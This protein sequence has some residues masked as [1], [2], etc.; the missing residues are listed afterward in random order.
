[1]AAPGRLDDLDRLL[2]LDPGGRGV[3]R[4]ATPG[5]ALA[6]A[7][8]LRRAR[9]VVIVTGFCVPPGIPE[10]DGPPGTAVLGRALRRLGARVRYVTDAAVRGSLAASL[11][12]LGEPPD[13]DVYHPGAEA[14]RALLGRETPSHLIAIE[15]PGRTT[16]G[17][18]LSARGESV[19]PWNSPLD[20][21]FVLAGK[22]VRPQ[23][24]RSSNRP[25]TA[26][27][28][29]A[30]PATFAV[31]DGGNEIGMG[32]VRPRLAREGT[33]MARIASAVRVDYLVVAGVSNWGA[34]GI[35]AALSRLSGQMLLHGA[36][37]ERRLI[38][39]CVE[40]GAVD[41]ITR[42]PEPTVDGL[43]LEA[44]AGF[45]ALLGRAVLEP[46]DRRAQIRREVDR[47]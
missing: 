9:R 46:G 5:A 47:V 44:H 26:R 28:G 20:E 21:L 14:A 22:R 37:E 3:T 41:G 11:S 31:G 23:P 17:E 1:V 25:P 42:R 27:A 32:N 10:T 29:H 35:V 34:Y 45:V 24:S 13:V 36:A 2:A 19:A 8:G 15:R 30:S 16:T 43:P 39:A 6:A 12:A 38:E 40:A 33:L 7:H 4:Y 18:Y